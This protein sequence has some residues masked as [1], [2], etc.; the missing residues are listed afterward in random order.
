MAYSNAKLKSNADRAPWIVQ[1]IEESFGLGRIGAT[2]GQEH[3]ENYLKFVSVAVCYAACAESCIKISS[4][5]QGILNFALSARTEH[6]PQA[7]HVTR[8][9][10]L[11][12]TGEAGEMASCTDRCEE[13][14]V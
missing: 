9:P 2:C 6:R 12:A 10:D 4:C 8:G 3:V 13:R 7:V 5:A 11:L 1:N 14:M